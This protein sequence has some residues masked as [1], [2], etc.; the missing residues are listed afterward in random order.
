[1]VQNEDY[2]V[3]IDGDD[4]LQD[5]GAVP[6]ARVRKRESCDSLASAEQSLIASVNSSVGWLGITVPPFC[7]LF[8]RLFQHCA[9]DATVSTLRNQASRL[10]QPKDTGSLTSF[11][12]PNEQLGH[13]RSVVVICNAG[14]TSKAGKLCHIA[15]LLIDKLAVDS[16]FHTISW[17]SYKARRPVKSTAAA[18]IIAAGEGVEHGK[19][20]ADAYRL[21]LNV[22]IY[23]VVV[24][25]SK[26]LFTALT[27]KRQF[28]GQSIRGDI[29]AT[30]YE[31]EGRTVAKVIW[32]PGKLNPAD[33]RTKFDNPITSAVSQLLINGFIP[34]SQDK[35]ESCSSDRSYG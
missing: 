34:F 18:E 30:R 8:S 15:G 13:E 20:I 6:L 10:N 7:A 3:T 27:T 11:K 23:L 22:S 5:I 24:V 32:V 21:L 29:G 35:P 26:N 4:K 12:R 9:P 19:V 14:R 16:I 25:D 1:M 33:I 17:S 28:V 2:T 31:F